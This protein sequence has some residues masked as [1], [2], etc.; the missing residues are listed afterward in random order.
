[1]NKIVRLTENDLVRL[2]KR[3]ISEQKYKLLRSILGTTDNF[4][5]EFGENYADDVESFLFKTLSKT[6]NVKID[7][8]S[9]KQ[10]L[11]TNKGGTLRTDYLVEII[12]GV[13]DGTIPKSMID[14]LPEYLADGTPFRE[15][16]RVLINK[17][18][19]VSG[20]GNVGNLRNNLTPHNPYNK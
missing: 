11:I 19:Q 20:I 6:K 10:A 7:E 18:T 16:V 9:G 17:P 5:K 15:E 2:T 1:M 14:R 12:A 13:R 4:V 3:V 8:I